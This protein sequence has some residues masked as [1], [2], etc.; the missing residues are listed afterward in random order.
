MLE[1]IEIEM[2]VQ[3]A[4]QIVSL[5]KCI[6]R[7]Y[8]FVLAKG[9]AIKYPQP[10]LDNWISEIPENR[11]SWRHCETPHHSRRTW[12]V[13]I[14][15][16]VMLNWYWIV[17][18]HSPNVVSQKNRKLK[19]GWLPSWGSVRS[20]MHLCFNF[21]SRVAYVAAFGCFFLFISVCAW[22]DDRPW[23]VERNLLNSNKNE[24]VRFNTTQNQLQRIKFMRFSWLASVV[25]IRIFIIIDSKRRCRCTWTYG[26]VGR[27]VQVNPKSLRRRLRSSQWLA[28]NVECLF[29]A[30][31]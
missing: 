21:N 8:L 26:R 10:T 6:N 4:E 3:V 30:F 29:V 23:R 2:C 20:T 13:V 5:V 31:T 7:F 14:A 17:H 24:P 16:H 11:R 25:F 27:L 22:N 28:A 1:R 19:I 15:K 9:I 12:W 18:L